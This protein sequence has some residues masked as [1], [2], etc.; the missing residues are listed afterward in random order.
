[1]NHQPLERESDGIVRAHWDVI[2]K[3]VDAVL[4]ADVARFDSEIEEV[5]DS[6][7]GQSGQ[8]RALFAY[9]EVL[10]GKV[11]ELEFGHNLS[12]EQILAIA[13]CLG[14]QFA[15][16]WPRNDL[17]HSGTLQRILLS[18]YRLD[19]EGERI[20]S[21]AMIPPILAALGALLRELNLTLDQIRPHLAA[22]SKRN[23]SNFRTLEI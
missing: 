19:I 14:P 15:V 2:S 5:V 11:L 20:V 13:D 4:N 3:T 10:I 8:A 22:W 1:M 17:P 23:Q 18:A 12:R 7:Y 9:G 6:S 21:Y 16:I